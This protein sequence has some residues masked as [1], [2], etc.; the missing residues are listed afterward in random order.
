MCN[1]YFKDRLSDVEPKISIKQIEK[2]RR[3]GKRTKSDLEADVMYK[4]K[5]TSSESDDV[6]K[7]DMAIDTLNGK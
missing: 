4:R 7:Y 3:D 5:M 2:L 6:I 1:P